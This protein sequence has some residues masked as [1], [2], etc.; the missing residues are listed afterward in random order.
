M[1]SKEQKMKLKFYI[2]AIASIVLAFIVFTSCTNFEGHGVFNSQ[3]LETVY[4]DSC[5]TLF[6]GQNIDAGAVCVTLEDDGM[7]G[8]NLVVTYATTG[9]WEILET[10]LWVGQFLSHMPQTRKGNPQVGHFP[11]ASGDISGSS[12][13]T[14]AF[15]IP[16]DSLGGES[17]LCDQTWLFAAHA[18]LGIPDGSGGYLQ[19]ESAW[20]DGDRMVQR[21]NW[22]TYFA[23]YFSCDDP[24]GGAEE[25]ETSF[26]YGDSYATCFLDIDVEEPI[27]EPDYQRW[28]WTNGPLA[29]GTYTFDIYAGANDCDLL[30]GTQVGEL[31]VVYSS[32]TATVTF[33]AISGWELYET[34]LYVGCELLHRNVNDLFTVAPSQ[35]PYIHEGLDGVSTDTYTIENLSCSGGIYVVAHAVVCEEDCDETV[36]IVYGMTRYTGDVYKINLVTGTAELSFSSIAPIPG[37]ATPNGLGYDAANGRMYYCNYPTVTTLYFWDYETGTETVA[38]VLS[39]SNGAADFYNGKYYYIAAPGASDDLY[40]VTFNADG[41]VLS[42]EKIADISGNTHAWTFSG[43]IA[44]KDGVVYGWGY[45]GGYEYFTYNLATAAFT[46]Y[47]STFGS[48][49]QLAFGSNG[50]VLYGHKSANPGYFYIVDTTDGS[51][52]PTP[53]YSDGT[54]YTDCASGWQC[55]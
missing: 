49:L 12:T 43:D 53:V 21:G 7:G 22:A 51:V 45:S 50:D 54:L 20:A 10:H 38:G 24:Q 48:S 16:I 6:A 46:V 33:S 18:A 19:T 13:T 28:G 35:Y 32:G 44:V 27:G 31:T 1:F 25:C 14:Y 47:N 11:Y 40:E 2:P 34:H 39:R 4:M 9:D 29:E 26:A 52:T 8:Q 17:G 23:L 55:Q 37:S 5:K 30:G 41:T 36:G 3:I 42:E 15:I